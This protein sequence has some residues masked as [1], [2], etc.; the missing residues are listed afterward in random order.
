M[1]VTSSPVSPATARP[2]IALGFHRSALLPAMTQAITLHHGCGPIG[3]GSLLL[4]YPP[5]PMDRT[6]RS[7]TAI[8]GIA[9]ASR[10]TDQS[11]GSP[12]PVPCKPIRYAW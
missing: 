6:V 2:D 5:D 1:T 7:R 9:A 12:A 3:A 8:A 10:R 11:A 4:G